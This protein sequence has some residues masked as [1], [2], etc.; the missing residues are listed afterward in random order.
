M[1][2]RPLRLVVLTDPR[3]HRRVRSSPQVVEPGRPVLLP[4]ATLALP[5]VT[6]VTKCHQSEHPGSTLLCTR[7]NRHA[8][9]HYTAWV[10]RFWPHTRTYD[11]EV[12]AR[13]PR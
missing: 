13:W 2:A 8:G 11:C 10:R 7:P 3:P 12:L 9:D 5:L 6:A 1:Q 4:P